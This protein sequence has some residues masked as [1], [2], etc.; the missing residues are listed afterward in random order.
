MAD[1]SHTT[2]I[3]QSCFVVQININLLKIV[4]LFSTESINKSLRLNIFRIPL[5]PAVFHLHVEVSDKKRD[6]RLR[7]RCLSIPS[8][9]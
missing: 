7:G 3:S 9:E 2:A 8:K 6:K 1:C 5:I 4:L